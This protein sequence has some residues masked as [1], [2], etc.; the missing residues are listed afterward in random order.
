MQDTAWM[1][2]RDQ[3]TGNSFVLAG[4]LVRFVPVV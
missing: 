3:T 1:G 4:I 2:L